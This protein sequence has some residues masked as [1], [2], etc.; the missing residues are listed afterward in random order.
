MAGDIPVQVAPLQSPLPL[1]SGNANVKNDQSNMQMKKPIKYS[2]D[3]CYRQSSSK[4]KSNK[5]EIKG[6][7]FAHKSI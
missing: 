2:V 6:M 4:E 7:G 1:V 3:K 5:K